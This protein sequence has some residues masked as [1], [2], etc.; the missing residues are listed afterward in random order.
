MSC[1]EAGVIALRRA[2]AGKHEASNDQRCSRD[3]NPWDTYSQR[4][5]ITAQY[6]PPS[7]D[8]NSWRTPRFL[9]QLVWLTR[10]IGVACL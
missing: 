7:R 5:V 10:D 4:P 8:L 3:L 2:A 1:G 6:R 9:A